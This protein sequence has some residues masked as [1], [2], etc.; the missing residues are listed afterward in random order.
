MAALVIISVTVNPSTIQPGGT[1][2]ITILAS[3][4]DVQTVFL[5]GT[6]RDAAGNVKTVS[7]TVNISAPLTYTMLASIGTITQD[8]VNLNV[9][10][11]THTAPA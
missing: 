3:G 11:Y 7:G 4:P 1:S 6:V 2:T 8:P 5:T 9:F 10:H